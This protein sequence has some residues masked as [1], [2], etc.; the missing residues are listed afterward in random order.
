MITGA[1]RAPLLGFANVGIQPPLC[2]ALTGTPCTPARPRDCFR[3]CALADAPPPLRQRARRRGGECLRVD[4]TGSTF[5]ALRP[6]AQVTRRGI[7]PSTRRKISWAGHDVGRGMLIILP[8]DSERSAT[9]AHAP[10]RSD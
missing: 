2:S 5:G 8:L 9:V 4:G 3:F 6:V 7:R 1:T 10:Q